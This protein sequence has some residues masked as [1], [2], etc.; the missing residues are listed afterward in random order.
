[1]DTNASSESV[2]TKTV[3]YSEVITFDLPVFFSLETG[4]KILGPSRSLSLKRVYC[5]KLINPIEKNKS[6][7]NG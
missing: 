4:N 6:A 1:V 7:L 5:V 3:I 2:K